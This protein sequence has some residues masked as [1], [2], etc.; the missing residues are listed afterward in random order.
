MLGC[1]TDEIRPPKQ[2]PASDSGITIDAGDVPNQEFNDVGITPSC[3]ECALN[4]A[5]IDGECR[6]RPSCV[7]IICGDD[8]CGGFCGVCADGQACAIGQCE[9]I[10]AQCPNTQACENL[11]CGLDP[12][13]GEYC[14]ACRRGIRCEEG[15]CPCV[16]ECADREC[17]ADGCGGTCGRC[18]A[19]DVCLSGRCEMRPPDCP[20]TADCAGL[21]CDTERGSVRT[22]G[23]L[24]SSVAVQAFITL[25]RL[26]A[27]FVA[28][29]SPSVV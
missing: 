21:E 22:F 19:G 18:S 28:V 24:L 15:H 27:S 13:C 17:G 1:A 20:E 4:E 12:V 6:C 2:L 10:E 9:P 3:G 26:N 5:C 23:R 29:R 11:E 25:L 8:G 7:G 14:G 16:A